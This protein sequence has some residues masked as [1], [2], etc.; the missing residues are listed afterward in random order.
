MPAQVKAEYIVLSKD[1]V[2][3]QLSVADADVRK[4]YDAHPERFSQG[5]ERRASHPDPGRQGGR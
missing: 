3:S 4:E 2:A 1:A 5:E